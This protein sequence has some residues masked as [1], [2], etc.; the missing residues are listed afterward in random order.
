M[1]SGPPRD[2][3]GVTV[4]ETGA[5]ERLNL[6]Y[7]SLVSWARRAA[8]VPVLKRSTATI[9]ALRSVLMKPVTFFVLVPGRD[10]VLFRKAQLRM[11]PGMQAA[12]RWLQL[13]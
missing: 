4:P 10:C 6:G 2:V 8:T 11:R 7:L 3:G 5:I 12:H 9:S 1:Q 13:G